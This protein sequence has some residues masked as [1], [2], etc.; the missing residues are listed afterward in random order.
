[1]NSPTIRGAVAS[2]VVT[3]PTDGLC[4][5]G[6]DSSV[7]LE[8]METSRHVK[9]RAIIQSSKWK[10]RLEIFISLNAAEKQ[11][12]KYGRPQAFLQTFAVAMDQRM[13]RPCDCGARA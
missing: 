5:S 2:G 6:M 13:V 4:P 10:R 1:M 7:F 8:V 12:E 3:D 9:C 11:A